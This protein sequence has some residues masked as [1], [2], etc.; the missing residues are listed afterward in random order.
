[1]PLHNAWYASSGSDNP[2]QEGGS[3]VLLFSPVCLGITGRAGPLGRGARAAIICMIMGALVAGCGRIDPSKIAAKPDP[4]V[5]VTEV[6]QTD[7][8]IT[9]EWVATLDGSNDVSVKARVQGY[10]QKQVYTNGSVVKTGDVLFEID[11]RPFQAA[12]EQAKANLAVA[13]A[14]QTQTELTAKRQVELFNTHTVSEQERDEAVQANAAAAANVLA[15]KAAVDTAALNLGYTKVTAPVDGI[16]G[17]AKPGV[18]DLVGPSSGDLCSMATVNPIKA[19]FQITEQQYL[20]T[21]KALNA[22]TTEALAARVP[23][24][25]L[26]L[27]DGSVYQHKGKLSTVNLGV[28]THTGT[29]VLEA[30]FPNEGNIL[31]PGLFARVRA[32]VATKEGALLVPQRAVTEMQGTYR[33]AVVDSSNKVSVRRVKTGP[34]HGTEWVIEQGLKPGERVVAEGV[35]FATDGITVQTKPYVPPVADP[36]AAS[37]RQTTRP[38]FQLK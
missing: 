23:R 32:D 34:R 14:N 10:I 21:A 7:V 31:R 37:D 16:A 8:P 2:A 35:Q 29:I 36:A 17:I 27:A 5:M 9:R 25:E 13:Q 24:I 6:R 3:L 4:T 11:P 18:G 33:V 22:I 1:M 15:M 28:G 12:L 30:L 20:M 38:E 26:V 19:V